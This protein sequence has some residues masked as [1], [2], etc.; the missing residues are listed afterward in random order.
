MRRLGYGDDKLH[1]VVNRHQKS[2]IDLQ[3]IADNLGVPVMA[4]VAND[5]PTV[6]KA[7]DRGQL[8]SDVAPRCRV[9]EDIMRTARVFLGAP[10]TRERRG[11]LRGLFARG[12]DPKRSAATEK[13]DDEM[14][15]GD[16]PERASEAV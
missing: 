16:E 4:A 6:R 13:L 8:V 5:Y 10:A 7:I 1:L 2:E 11:F 9:V 3:S 14:E 15:G 12:G